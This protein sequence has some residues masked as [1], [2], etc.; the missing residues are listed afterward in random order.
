[1]PA[2]ILLA[3][4]SEIRRRLLENAGVTV[5]ALPARIDEETITTSLVSE[6]AKPRDIADALAEYKAQKLGLKHMDRLVLGCDQVL[7]HDGG[8]LSKPQS[9][10]E[11]AAQLQ[12]LRG[13]THRLFSA[14]VIYEQGKPVWRAVKEAKLTMRE[15]SDEYLHAYLDRNWDEIKYCVGGYQLEAEGARLF[16]H[17]TGDYF[18]VLGM[19]LLEILNYLSLK[20]EIDG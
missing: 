4:Q 8:I 2:P 3:S 11:A 1:M 17:V 10:E 6:G 9:R 13:R 7:E 16:A 20:G 5:E 18:T 14:A 12:A 19:P 15:F